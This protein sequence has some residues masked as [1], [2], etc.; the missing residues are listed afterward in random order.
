MPV[1]SDNPRLIPPSDNTVLW[2]YMDFASFLYLIV[3]KNLVF[4]RIDKYPDRNEGTLPETT[5]KM[6]DNSFSQIGK[7]IS[8][9]IEESRIFHYANCWCMDNHE[10]YHMWMVFSKEKGVAIKSTYTN[11]ADS[12]QSEEN[13]YPTIINYLNFEKDSFQNWNNSLSTVSI[14]RHEFSAEKEFRLIMAWPTLVQGRVDKKYPNA[15][16]KQRKSEYL[17][18]ETILC[19]IDLKKMISEIVISP[20]A[21]GWYVDLIK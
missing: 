20:M 21:H 4:K 3:F 19:P 15:T 5:R 11:L 7:E 9:L 13:V 18:T 10:N 6:I 1:I 8:V 12:I 14:K 17:L 2:K 16:G